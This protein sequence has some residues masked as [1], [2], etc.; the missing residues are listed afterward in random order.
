MK[1]QAINISIKELIKL[2][3]ELAIMEKDLVN[4]FGTDIDWNRKVLVGIVNRDPEC[5][6]TWELE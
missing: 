3:K 1:R 6:D 2:I 5:S 4:K